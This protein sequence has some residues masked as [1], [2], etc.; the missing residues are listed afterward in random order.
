MEPAIVEA[1]SAANRS[2]QGMGEEAISAKIR[3]VDQSW[4]TP[5]SNPA[6]QQILEAPGSRLLRR[7]RER[8]PRLLRITV[9]DEKGAT[10]AATHKTLDYFQADEE[11]WQNIYAQGRGAVSLTDV[12]YDEATKSY[13][14]GVGVPVLQEGSNRVIGTLDALV[15]VS[16]IFPLVNRVQIGP[17][18]RAMLV[19]ED[20]TIISAS[21]GVLSLKSKSEHYAAVQEAVQVDPGL[22]SGCLEANIRGA[23]R[24][25]IGFADVGLKTDYPKL[26]WYTLVSQDAREAFAPVALVARLLG[27]LSL[28]GLA[29]V[30]MLGAY[31]ALHRKRPFTEIGDLREEKSK[32]A[33]M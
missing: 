2:Y 33:Q 23:G 15:D 18:G 8:S 32:A 27:F 21:Q 7:R 26:G 11:Y 4:D 25:L 3:K 28:L 16:S 12:L 29:S 22:G 1:V 6:V 5:A 19:K 14:I 30:T 13:Y 20:G 17:W 31:F 24:N 10:I 9:T